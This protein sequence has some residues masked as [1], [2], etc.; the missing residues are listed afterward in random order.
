MV[1][2]KAGTAVFQLQ[3]ITQHGCDLSAPRELRLCVIFHLKM[4][5]SRATGSVSV[6]VCVCARVC[7]CVYRSQSPK[8][9]WAG[10]YSCG[11]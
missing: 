6:G 5:D 2:I 10:Y 9:N 4:N 7:V 3:M 8:W 1:H 11:D